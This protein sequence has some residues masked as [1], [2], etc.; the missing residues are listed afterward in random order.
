MHF[1]EEKNCS[2]QTLL[3]NMCPRTDV[4]YFLNSIIQNVVAFWYNV[5]L[6]FDYYPRPIEI[7]VSRDTNSP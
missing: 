4:P 7:M 5:D 3:T 2:M 6:N 1:Y